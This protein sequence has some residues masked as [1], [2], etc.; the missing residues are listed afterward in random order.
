MVTRTWKRNEKQRHKMR[1][2]VRRG[3]SFLRKIAGEENAESSRSSQQSPFL[4]WEKRLGL[5]S[6][7]HPDEMG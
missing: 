3:M 5:K 2:G 1:C 7:R 4:T 6:K